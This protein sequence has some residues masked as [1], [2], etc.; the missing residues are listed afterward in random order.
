[1]RMF[2]YFHESKT[3]IDRNDDALIKETR[4]QLR[5]YKTSKISENV[6]VDCYEIE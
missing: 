6:I 2:D 3:G 5:V 4:R 1:M